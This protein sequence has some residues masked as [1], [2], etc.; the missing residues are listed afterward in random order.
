MKNKPIRR[1]AQQP[2]YQTLESRNVLSANPIVSLDGGTLTIEGSSGDDTVY[3]R[4]AHG[5]V[6]ATYQTN[7]NG[8]QTEYFPESEVNDFRFNGRA[9]DDHIVNR[10][11]LPLVAYGNDGNDRLIGGRGNDRLHGGSGDDVLNLSLIHI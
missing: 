6:Q 1:R 10:T 2:D 7:G 5:E 4:I 8:F 9:G 11:E 3:V